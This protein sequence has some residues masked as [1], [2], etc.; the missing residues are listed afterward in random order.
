MPSAAGLLS[1]ASATLRKFAPLNRQHAY[2]RVIT[3]TGG[4]PLTHK[5]GTV[6]T[7]DTKFDPQPTFERTGRQHL[8]GG[9]FKWEIVQGSDDKG[10]LADDFEFLFSA[11]AIT[12]DQIYD[13]NN[14]IVLKDASGNEDV[15]SISDAEEIGLSGTDICYVVYTHSVRRP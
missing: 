12:Y 2:L 10:K 14:Q 9:H 8:P 5:A 4:D 13:P 15:M 7:E 3:R 6:S 1:K 11:D